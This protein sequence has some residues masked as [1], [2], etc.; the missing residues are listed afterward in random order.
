MEKKDG[1]QLKIFAAA[2]FLNDFGADM[3]NSFW[4]IFLSVY[5]HA[6]VA[7]IGFIDGLGDSIVAFSQVFSGYLS[8][9][10]RKR[11]VFIWLGYFFSS[12]SKI[13]YALATSSAQIIPLRV[14]DRSGKMREPP[15]DAIVADITAKK[16]RGHS[17]GFIVMM[18][19]LGAVLGIILALVLIKFITL[20]TLFLIAG[21]P[22]LIA[23][24]LIFTKIRERKDGG[25]KLYSGMKIKDISKRFK[26]FLAISA[27]FAISSF[28]YS[29]LLLFVKDKGFAIATIPLF[30]LVYI[31]LASLSS[32][33]FGNLADKIGRKSVLVMSYS[34]W[35]LALLVFIL[36]SNVIG[37]IIAFCLFG[38]YKGSAE[39]SQRAF[40]SELARKKYRASSLG[41]FRLVIGICALPASLIAGALWVS[42]GKFTPLYFSLA[43]AVISILLLLTMSEKDGDED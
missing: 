31:S 18:D 17:F 11:K 10:L 3:I 19:S 21:I 6:S 9:R 35:A 28:S 1:K 14:L 7:M 32:I 8:D 37:L 22:P 42:F 39:P 43:L 41:V 33:P 24:I 2:S 29:F 40:V 30:Y 25:I 4:P 38:L 26:L 34:F 23:S 36:N 12:L 16:E 20:K 13:G 27:L 5:L 15:R